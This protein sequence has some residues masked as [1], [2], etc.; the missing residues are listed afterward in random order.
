M[1]MLYSNHARNL[2]CLIRILMPVA[3]LHFCLPSPFLTLGQFV[4]SIV[5][6][7]L[8]SNLRLTSHLWTPLSP[9]FLTTPTAVLSVLAPMYSF[10]LTFKNLFI[11]G[12]VGSSLWRVGFSLVAAARGCL[13]S[14][15]VR[16]FSLSLR[17]ASSVVVACELSCSVA[18]GILV[19]RPG[20]EPGSP[21]LEGDS[22][23][24][25]HQGSP[26]MYCFMRCAHILKQSLKTSCPA[27][28][29]FSWVL[30]QPFYT[31]YTCLLVTHEPF[32]TVFMCHQQTGSFSKFFVEEG[33]AYPVSSFCVHHK[34]VSFTS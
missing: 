6:A 1:T 12:C 27:I 5:T 16:V 13:S 33:T 29:V 23:P 2:L 32:Y 26:P 21:A 14:C 31:V 15:D 20:I 4:I 30:A 11:F 24:L 28:V 7:T 8:T 9:V 10:F 18:C 17:H 25:D 22:L 19:P 34:V 3:T